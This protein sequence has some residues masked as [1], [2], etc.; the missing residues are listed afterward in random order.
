MTATTSQIK[1]CIE[2]CNC[3]WTGQPEEQRLVPSASLAKMGVSGHDHVCPKC[4]HD[5]FYRRV[6]PQPQRVGDAV[7][8]PVA[9]CSHQDR[10]GT[11]SHP[12]RVLP[13]C[14]DGCCPRLPETLRFRAE[15]DFVIRDV[16]ETDTTWDLHLGDG[17]WVSASKEEYPVAPE[18]GDIVTLLLPKVVQIVTP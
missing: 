14:H 2:C 12:D 10:D 5:D 9:G 7:I 1:F 17:T 6:I 11:C 16:T 15:Q 13:E 3:G 4:G 8:N 18:M